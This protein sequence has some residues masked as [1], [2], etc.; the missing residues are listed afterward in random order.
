MSNSLRDQLLNLG[1]QA[2]TPEPKRKP[3]G[4]SN[5]HRSSTGKPSAKP[6]AGG[7]PTGAKSPA[8]VQTRRDG[9]PGGRRKPASEM[10][11]GKAYALR[12]QKEKEERI[13]AEQA[14]QEAARL[15]REARVKLGAFLQG[16]TLNQAEADIARHFEYGGKIKR[17]YVTADQLKSLNAGELGV[18]QLEGRYL[19]VAVETLVQAEQIFPA[20]VA[21][22]VDPNAPA[23]DDPYSDPQ[24]KVPDDLVW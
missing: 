3:Q 22:K 9:K 16:K 18:V 24:Y 14:K 10:D 2:P 8:G 17:I 6:G 13:A 20:C 15:R 11:L 19:L 4:Q 7:R 12:A 5:P 21:L 23:G 1:F